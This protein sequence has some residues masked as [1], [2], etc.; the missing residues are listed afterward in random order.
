MQPP[1]YISH[2][3]HSR[4]Q[5]LPVLTL[6]EP[7]LTLH[8]NLLFVIAVT[9][10]QATSELNILPSQEKAAQSIIAADVI[11]IAKKY[12]EANPP[13]ATGQQTQTMEQLRA[14][15]ICAVS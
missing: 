15:V 9:V 12:I 8:Y 14:A 13:L 3:S 6:S 4:V 10:A 1:P 11:I 5:P 7:D 2:Q